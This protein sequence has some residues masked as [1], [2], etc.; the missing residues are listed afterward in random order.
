MAALIPITTTGDTLYASS[1]TALGRLAI[2]ATNAVLTVVGGVPAWV[3]GGI[4]LN[5]TGKTADITTTNLTSSP[6]AG[7]YEVKVYLMCTTNDVTAGA[8]TV[9]IGWTDSV[10]ATTSTPITAFSLAATGR[11][12]GRQIVQVASGNITYA[13]AV[14]GGIGYGT[15][16]YAIHVRVVPH[17]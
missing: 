5:N 2:G 14:A 7:V 17:G 16:V 15:S 4:V 1:A 10:G 11:T 12:T 6:T 3:A 9:T 8:L 13:V